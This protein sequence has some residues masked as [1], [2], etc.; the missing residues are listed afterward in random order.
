MDTVLNWLWQGGVVAAALHL[1]LLVLQRAKAKV[2]YAVCWA[3]L[4]L[5]VTLPALP[6]VAATTAASDAILPAQTDAIVSLPDAWWTS[7]L[8][9]L[10]A[11]IVWASIQIVRLVSA[12]VA[13]RRAR[14]S[15]HAFPS[16]LE[17]LL[18]HWRRVRLTGRSTTLVVSDSVT[19][20]AVLGCGAPMIAVA[21]SLVR[22]LDAED[23]DR[24][25]IHEWAHVQRYD[26]VVNIL[27][28]VA[29][30]VAGWHP[31]L[32][33]VDRRLHLERE[34]ACDEMTVAITGSPRSYAACLMKLSTTR[35]TSRLMQTAPTVLTPSGLSQRVVRIMSVRRFI[36]P[37]WS[38]A[39]AAVIVLMLCLASSAVGAL[40]VVGAAAFTQPLLL[41][42]HLPLAWRS[43]PLVA[44][45]PA[46]ATDLKTTRPSRR[47]AAESFSPLP[48]AIQQPSPESQQEVPPAPPPPEAQ[49]P[50][51][52]R[53]PD[54]VP[55]PVPI[56]AP[57][58]A[59]A[60]H[61]Q[62]PRPQVTAEP[63]PSPW[64]EVAAGGTALGKKSKDAGLKAA[65]FFTR[66]GRRV[67][68]SF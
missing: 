2:R 55:E 25:L 3:S 54:P 38:G 30:V 14:A 24:V 12:I 31:A 39:L 35:G 46:V 57:E 67:A 66:L 48:Q 19:S 47:A 68:G 52:A 65:G 45:A 17:A 49:L 6:P 20:A 15:S 32:W 34:I 36:A 27:Q 11:W 61:P 29:R 43:A 26:D 37:V 64:S 10:G 33:W 58:V 50:D 60:P 1:M 7:T 4:L 41:A 8:V 21:P 18:P 40:T 63:P 9:I 51:S 62:Q 53:T 59:S 22:T 56:A 16:D 5:I 23:L 13:I 28:I 42:E 44:S